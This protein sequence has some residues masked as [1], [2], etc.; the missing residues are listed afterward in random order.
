MH[1]AVSMLAGRRHV[2]CVA[3]AQSPATVAPFSSAKPGTTLPPWESVK[4]NE[5]KKLTDYDF[6]DDGGTIVLHAQGRQR[7]E[8]ARHPAQRRRQDAPMIQCRW[9]YRGLIDGADNAVAAKE[10]SPVR[11]VLEFDGD[12]SKLGFGDRAAASLAGQL[13]RPRAAVRAARVRVVEQR[14]GR[15][16]DPQSAHQA[17]ADDR[18]VERSRRRRQVADAHAQRRRGLQARVRRG[19][20]AAQPTSAS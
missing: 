3:A 11:V 9:K 4:I 18:R 7:R 5:R 6:V 20:G 10:D 17:R 16:R 15:Y 19:A 2:P 14:A 8:H 1:S 13:D 12:K